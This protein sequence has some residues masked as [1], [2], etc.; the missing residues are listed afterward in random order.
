[1]TIWRIYGYK[2]LD[3]SFTFFVGTFS[4][5]AGK[6][7]PHAITSHFPHEKGLKIV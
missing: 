7:F 3:N 2:A 6:F 4:F 1:M 5:L